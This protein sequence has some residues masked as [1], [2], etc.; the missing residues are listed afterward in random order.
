VAKAKHGFFISLI[1]PLLFIVIWWGCALRVNNPVILPEVSQVFTLLSRPTENIISM[2]S[3]LSNVLVSLIRVMV[4]YILAVLVAIPLGIMMG[5]YSVVFNLF[6]NFLGLFRPIPP[7]AWVPLVL[8][9]FGVASFATL[10]GIE[11]GQLYIWLNN[12]KISMIFIIFIGAFFPVV[13]S[14]I[15]GVRSVNKTLIDSAQVLG[16]DNRDIFRK[17]LLPAAAPSIV[18]GM[19]IGLG[20][21]WMCLVSAEMLPGSI[22]GVGYLIT[23][24]YTIAHTDVV[25]AG[26]ISIGAVGAL[27]DC[28]FR[29]FE[30]RKFKWQRLTR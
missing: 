19:R 12:L 22:S 23:H 11:E 30:S 3:L 27:L 25:I 26:M 15:Y 6:N 17:I 14:S 9:W 21:A 20:V 28:L 10:F 5:Y 7:L 13:T 29:A 4:G 1:I 24:A 2:G 8:A 16:A 18:N